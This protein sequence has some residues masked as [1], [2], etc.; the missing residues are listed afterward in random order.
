L[1]ALETLFGHDNL[2][3]INLSKLYLYDYLKLT[4]TNLSF[5]DLTRKLRV[6]E[7]VANH[8]KEYVGLESQGSKYAETKIAMRD[9]Y[10]KNM[11]NIFEKYKNKDNTSFD[12]TELEHADNTARQE[13]IEIF[14]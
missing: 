14:K 7:E 12:F 4:E 1:N 13:V 11:L 2:Q 5:K 8:I 6:P 3:I 10:T 9:Q